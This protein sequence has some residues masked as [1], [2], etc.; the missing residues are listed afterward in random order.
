M[1]LASPV[2]VPT[3]QIVTRPGNTDGNEV[4]FVYLDEVTHQYPN[5]RN[6][7]AGFNLPDLA[8]PFFVRHPRP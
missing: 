1:K 7:P 4:Y 8:W 6:N 3:P 5:G 2:S